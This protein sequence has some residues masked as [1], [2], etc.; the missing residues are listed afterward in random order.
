ME[1]S[2]DLLVAI[3]IGMSCTGVAY[4]NKARNSS[5]IKV[6]QDWPG[7]RLENKVPT[8]LTY[9]VNSQS[10]RAK[11][12]N[13]GFLCDADTDRVNDRR[14]EEW[15]KVELGKYDSGL[16]HQE[17]V[18]RLYIDYMERLYETLRDYFSPQVLN[19]KKWE[20]ANIQF[21]F[22][23]P[24]T[25][26]PDIVDVFKLLARGAGFGRYDGFTIA[27]NLTEPQ[28][29]AAYTLCEE[30]IFENGDSVLIVD[31]GGGTVDLCL[32]TIDD[33]DEGRA[34]TTE[35]NPVVGKLHCVGSTY[36]DAE[37]QNLVASR[38]HGIAH[39][40]QNPV[41][42]VA[43]QMM[44]S[45][46]FQSNKHALGRTQYDHE[47]C[48]KIKIPDLRVLLTDA[49]L[50]ISRGEMEFSW[51]ELE[52][53]F[54]KQVSGIVTH[55][56]EMMDNLATS[57]R[58]SINVDHVLLSGGLCSSKYVQHK[59]KEYFES[60]KHDLL[61]SV[62]LHVSTEPQLSVCRGLLCNLKQSL[63]NVPMFPRRCA[64]ASFGIPY[65][66]RYGRRLCDHWKP[67]QRE[68]RGAGRI[69]TDQFNQKWIVGS[70]DW[71]IKK[72]GS[73][74]IEGQKLAYNYCMH[75]APDIPESEWFGRVDIMTS[76][77][78]PPPSYNEIGIVR[79]LTWMQVDLSNTQRCKVTE[80]NKKW[81][82]RLA[83]Q[84]H[85]FRVQFTI[86]AEVGAAE[87]S[88]RCVDGEGGRQLSKPIELQ[89]GF[90]DDRATKSIDA[91]VVSK[92]EYY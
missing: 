34:S 57:L 90:E 43:W 28:A 63:E 42:D 5:T 46:A 81:Y 83:G 49:S 40:L 82:K 24:A 79:N 55:V 25:W 48:F 65:R 31:A 71:F 91:K 53:L 47:D 8:R 36:I 51:R 19:G 70:M 16:E 22:S 54:D 32:L 20:Y 2:P 72:V 80:M 9:E 35:L 17:F 7:R 76:L 77:H 13:W 33:K 61:K 3:D 4:L 67:V 23:V 14:V 66:K 59:M 64:R 60:P 78:N 12:V 84:K 75:F 41:E 21:V 26:S 92:N 62:K 44:S 88:F 50:R 18:K 37:F 39:L 69:I 86:E 74:V 52:Q 38:L 85:H 11:P 27:V 73:R 1:S 89:I 58:G 30:G 45:T 87:V 10:Q 29:V 6:F 68:A 56:D 15:F